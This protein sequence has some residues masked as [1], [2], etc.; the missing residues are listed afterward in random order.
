MVGDGG[1]KEKP[2]Y[3]FFFLIFQKPNTFKIGEDKSVSYS[4][5]KIVWGN[6]QRLFINEKTQKTP[7]HVKR[8]ST[9]LV[10]RKA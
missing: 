4:A 2:F 3:V 8:H 6:G 1:G 7:N 5:V 9:P 10:E